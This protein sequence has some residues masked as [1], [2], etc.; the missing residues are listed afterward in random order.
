MKCGICGQDIPG[1]E[2]DFAQ[3][4]P[5]HRGQSCMMQ[6]FQRSPQVVYRDGVIASLRKTISELQ[7]VMTQILKIAY[8]KV[9]NSK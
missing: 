8:Y 4:S 1:D 3:G 6:G 9:Q 7:E 5:I 2:V